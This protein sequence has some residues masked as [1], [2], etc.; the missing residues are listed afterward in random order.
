MSKCRTPKYIKKP[1]ESTGKS[2]DVSANLYASML[3]SPAWLDLTAQQ[4]TL[5]AY[6]K[7][8]LYGEKQKPT[9]DP[10]TF[11]MNQSKWA[12]R[13]RLYK[14]NNFKGFSRDM[15]ALILHG[16]VVCVECGATTRTKSVYKLSSSWQRWNTEAF[17][18]SPSEMT[19]SMTRKIRLEKG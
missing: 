19:L 7:L 16:F 6:C 18:L 14:K 9:E 8:Q 11:T 17:E 1:F 15:E 13:Y 12:D 10:T 2:N 5:Y 4:K 3:T